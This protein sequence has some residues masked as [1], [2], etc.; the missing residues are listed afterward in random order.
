[1]CHVRTLRAQDSP[2]GS[3]HTQALSVSL[4]IVLMRILG[5]CILPLV[6]CVSF[7]NNRQAV[8][9]IED[10]VYQ[11]ECV[12][13]VFLDNKSIELVSTSQ[14]QF[15][16]VANRYKGFLYYEKKDPSK[17]QYWLDLDGMHLGE[18]SDDFSRNV[19]EIQ[20]EVFAALKRI[21]SSHD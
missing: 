4:E 10:S 6:G 12:T 1:M 13:S 11:E 8:G 2:A 19:Y 9:W 21:C 18:S 17:Y 3:P 5:V 14:G 16:F 15:N 20:D 7:S